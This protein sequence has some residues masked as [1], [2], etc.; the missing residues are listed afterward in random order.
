MVIALIAL[1]MS[2]LT[3]GN[4]ST[5]IQTV[6][7]PPMPAY[8]PSAMTNNEE[9]EW[10]LFNQEAYYD[11]VIQFTELFNSY[12]TKRAKNGALMIRQG[13]TGSYKFAR[14]N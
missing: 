7:I 1:V 13:S 2:A 8:A 9:E 11:A 5:D 6:T 14:K 4:S 12:E 3:W 10:E